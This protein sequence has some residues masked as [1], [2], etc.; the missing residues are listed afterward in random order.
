MSRTV[1]PG[2]RTSLQS[3]SSTALSPPPLTPT[4]VQLPKRSTEITRFR[5][6][7]RVRPFIMEELQE[8]KEGAPLRSVVEMQGNRTILLDPKEDWAPKS[9]FEFDASIWSIPASQK[10]VKTFADTD[11]SVW[12]TQQD[13]YNMVAKG[14]VED[15]FEGYNSCIM[16]YGQTGSGKTYTMMG[17]YDT[18][19]TCGGD[20]EEGIIPRVCHDLFATLEERRR[21]EAEK[22]ADQQWEISIEVSFVEIY[23]EKV[24]DLLDPTLKRT[25]SAEMKDARIRQDP[26]SGPFIDGV[27]KYKVENWQ[28]C[29][30]LLERGS[31]HRTTCATLVHQQS[32]RSHAIF[33]LTVLKQQTIPAKDRYSDPIVHNLAGRINLVDLAGSERGGATDYV[34][35]SAKINASLLALRRVIDNLVERQNILMEQARADVTGGIASDKVLPQVPFRDSVLTWLLSDSIGGNARTTMVA[36]LSPLAKNYGDTLATLQW[37]SK[38]RNLVTVVKTNDP[39]TVVTDG[40]SSKAQDL[41]SSLFIQRQNMD[42]LRGE[43]QSKLDNI[44]TLEKDSGKKKKDA[45]RTLKE[46]EAAE[47][48]AAVLRAQK[49]VRR[50]QMRRAMAKLRG[51]LEHAQGTLSKARDARDAQ[52]AVLD[53]HQA[54]ADEAAASLQAVVAER[55]TMEAEIAESKR[56]RGDW[57]RRKEVVSEAY[58]LLQAE[59]GDA[60]ASTRKELDEQ[61]TKAESIKFEMATARSD[62]AAATKEANMM[63]SFL[64]ECPMSE[65]QFDAEAAALQQKSAEL[66]KKIADLKQ[67]KTALEARNQEL[68]EEY[69]KKAPKK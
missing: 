41:Q 66:A 15:A 53:G 52:Q 9:Q 61:E 46:A 44:A 29:V 19:A 47:L 27:T 16:T 4:S 12:S 8:M 28:S 3:P 26:N 39:Q 30:T 11:H 2:R 56:T 5:V 37:S 24:R 18:K 54:R 6:F 10:L 22:P 49:Y 57:E 36:T 35:E 32:S 23:M 42:M 59:L 67:K 63:S 40:M 17:N 20:G 62:A 31:L 50:W 69:R 33:Q 13:V 51:E 65:D 45:E 25:A 68:R 58:A 48:Q 21:Q 14:K 60:A 55:K 34:K 7:S 38:A 64:E 43:L 1:S